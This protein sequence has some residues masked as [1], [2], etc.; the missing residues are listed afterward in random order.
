VKEWQQFIEDHPSVEKW[1]KNRPANTQRIFARGMKGFCESV[2][3]TPDQWRDLDRF[4]ARDLA[5][6]YIEQFLPDHTSIA[7]TYMVA[8]KSFYRFKDGEL[9]PFDTSRGGKHGFQ[10]VRK[11]AAFEHIPNKT[12][13]YQLIDM[14]SNLRDRAIL[15][16]LFQSGCRLNVLQHILYG[17]VKDQVGKDIVT[18]KITQ[19][20]DFKL[21]SRN[22]PFYY[23][24]LN[25]EAAQALNRYCGVFHK[26]SKDNAPLFSTKGSTRS[27]GGTLPISQSYVLRIVK[28]CAKKAG[29]DPKTMW[30]HSLRKA[31]RKI[32][33]QANIDDD[34]DKEQLMGHA[35]KGSRE[36]YYD[37]KDIPLIMEAYKKCNFTRELP[38]SEIEKVRVESTREIESLKESLSELSSMVYLLAG[39][40]KDI[41]D[42]VLRYMKDG[43]RER[44]E[45]TIKENE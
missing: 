12:E 11:K 19:Q 23:T 18:L 25:G 15:L 9:L 37:K 32:V 20:L 27:K 1:L 40:K 21:R 44:L 8:F 33:R 24:F 31:F 22:I 7:N 45:R 28:S 4:K 35:I 6:S 39:G 14:A 10:V 30:V 17:Q 16:F 2:K 3:L 26:D 34:D 42:K 41:K 36:A 43:D 13:V 38:N 5:W 29:F